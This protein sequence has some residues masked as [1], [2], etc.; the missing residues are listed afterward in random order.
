MNKNEQTFQLYFLRLTDASGGWKG[1]MS[2]MGGKTNV[3]QVLVEKP[4]GWN[5]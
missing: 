5:P 1:Y 3:H 4:E 2:C